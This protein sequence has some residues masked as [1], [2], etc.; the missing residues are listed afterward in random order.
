MEHT[1]VFQT[2]PFTYV[3]CVSFIQDQ[4]LCSEGYSDKLNVVDVG[5]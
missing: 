4:V 5:E 3:S 2:F 1:S